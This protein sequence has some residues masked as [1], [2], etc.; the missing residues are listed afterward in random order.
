M[1]RWQRDHCI[2][3]DPNHQGLTPA[4]GSRL[5]GNVDSAA[6]PAHPGSDIQAG[7]MGPGSSKAQ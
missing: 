4:E 1:P 6:G 5:C 2:D 3:W 7:N